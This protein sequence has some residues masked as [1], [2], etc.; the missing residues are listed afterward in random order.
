MIK[1]SPSSLQGI[2]IT[3]SHISLRCSSE[4]KT[5]ACPGG[6]LRL[7]ADHRHTDP[8]LSGIRR[9]MIRTPETSLCHL[10]TT[11]ESEESHAPCKLHPRYG[12]WRTFPWGPSDQVFRAWATHFPP[13]VPSV[14]TILSFITTTQCQYIGCVLQQ[15]S[16]G[17]GSI[18]VG[19]KSSR[20]AGSWLQAASLHPQFSKSPSTAQGLAERA[21][22]R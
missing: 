22:P 5:T 4:T 15:A 9:L 13:S 20:P 18:T 8:R 19:A 17:F 16:G 7:H 11:G 12:L 1:Q 21:V 3:I 10:T 14:N 6:G 2:Y